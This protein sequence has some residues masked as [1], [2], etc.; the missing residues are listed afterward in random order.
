MTAR[1]RVRVRVLAVCRTQ[2]TDSLR[3]GVVSKE[4]ELMTTLVS[5][6]GTAEGNIEA[7]DGQL[8]KAMRD[9]KVRGPSGHVELCA[10]HA[11]LE[12]FPLCAHA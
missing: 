7:L 12:G 1:A 5:R 4:T 2:V 8:R 10:L 3:S 11:L 6:L 9:G